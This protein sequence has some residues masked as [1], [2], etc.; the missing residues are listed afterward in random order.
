VSEDAQNLLGR[1]RCRD[2]RALAR[3]ISLVEDGD[4]AAGSLLAALDDP[5]IE[6]AT[7]VGITGPGG[8]GKSTLTQRLITHYRGAGRRVGVVAI[9]PSSPISG[10]AFLGDRVRMMHHALDTDVVIRS[11][12]TRGRVGGLCA[13]AGA[14]VRLMGYAQC[15][16]VI[17]ETVGVGQAEVDIARLTDVTVLVLA[18]G[19]GDDIQ[20]LKA[21]LVELADV[22][23]VNKCDRPGAEALAAEME[24]L[25]RDG[26]CR[27]CRTCAATGQGVSELAGTIVEAYRAGGPEGIAERRRSCR[28]AEVLDWAAEL[29]QPRLRAELVKLGEVRGDPRTTARQ[30]LQAAGIDRL[31]SDSD[32]DGDGDGS[33]HRALEGH[34]LD[35]RSP[36]TRG[37]DPRGPENHTVGSPGAND[38]RGNHTAG[39][40]SFDNRAFGKDTGAA[41]VQSRRHEEMP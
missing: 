17:V 28:E 13:A 18:P 11:M 38:S 32:G 3:A 27:V 25:A 16:P 15:D 20:A 26:R 41:A 4:P 5:T 29:L 22:V 23:V 10:G 35:S 19:L 24:N 21:G 9:D 6:Q 14:A 1:I 40:H 36:D 12:A 2:A 31:D 34:G 37:R 39:N 33:E 7:T 8:V 30:L